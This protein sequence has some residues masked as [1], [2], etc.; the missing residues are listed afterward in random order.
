M[1]EAAPTPS[2]KM[3]QI[4][5]PVFADLQHRPLR[6]QPLQKAVLLVAARDPDRRDGPVLVR[7]G[8]DA[9]TFTRL[10]S[11]NLAPAQDVVVWATV[12]KGSVRV[13][14]FPARELEEAVW[15]SGRAHPHLSKRSR[16]W[17]DRQPRFGAFPYRRNV[18]S[19]HP[20]SAVWVIDI[21]YGK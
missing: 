19:S 8:C 16:D 21:S 7:F 15:R 10:P 14:P 20:D 1:V 9:I 11:H 4:V 3:S 2:F 17:V 13:G 18:R 5:I 6:L 12:I